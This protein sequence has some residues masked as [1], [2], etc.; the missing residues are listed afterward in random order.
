MHVFTFPSTNRTRANG[1]AY[2][3]PR[4]QFMN[5][6]YD[7]YE[8]NEFWLVN[9]KSILIDHQSFWF[10]FSIFF[11]FFLAVVEINERWNQW[12][13]GKIYVSLIFWFQVRMFCI[14]SHSIEFS[15][16]DTYSYWSFKDIGKE[17]SRYFASVGK[18]VQ[19]TH[20]K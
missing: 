13:D 17:S 6:C 11:F 3:P 9:R 8:R 7:N 5:Y 16:D 18:R 15:F 4:A 19:L 14:N 20:V 1:A 12:S 10:S 2:K